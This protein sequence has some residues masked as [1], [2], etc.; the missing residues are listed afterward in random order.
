MVAFMGIEQGLRVVSVF[1]V[2]IVRYR[3]KIPFWLPIG[4]NL[5]ILGFERDIDIQTTSMEAK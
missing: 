2:K 5:G 4:L 1:V 3:P